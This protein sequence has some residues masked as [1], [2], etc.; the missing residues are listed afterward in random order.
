MR[1]ELLSFRVAGSL[2]LAAGL[3]VATACSPQLGEAALVNANASEGTGAT[4]LAA[5]ANHNAA[6]MPQHGS[7]GSQSASN[8]TNS[9]RDNDNSYSVFELGGQYTTQ[10]GENVELAQVAGEKTVVAFIYTSCQA[11]CPLIVSALKRVEAGLTQAELADVRF[12]LVTIDP[13]HDTPQVLA[14]FAEERQLDTSRWT[15]LRGSAATL[16]ELAVSLDARYQPMGGGEIAHTNGFSIL[17]SQGRPLYHQP[18]FANV[19][20]AL[21]AI[22]N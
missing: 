10:R 6:H 13:E 16:R 17:D 20:G 22:R 12:V 14:R 5:A 15:L 21:N 18:D 3:L 8:T 1:P 11:T 19:D 9:L 2:A 4:A 7:A